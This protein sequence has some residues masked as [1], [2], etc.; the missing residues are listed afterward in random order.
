MKSSIA[1]QLLGD[2]FVLY[3]SIYYKSKQSLGIYPHRMGSQGFFYYS[4]L[5]YV[6]FPPL[7]PVTH[8]HKSIYRILLQFS[9]IFFCFWKLR[10]FL[11]F[12]LWVCNYK[13]GLHFCLLISE[14]LSLWSADWISA[15]NLFNPWKKITLTVKWLGR[16][17]TRERLILFF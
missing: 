3:P 17:E 8:P 2:F 9:P 15:V 7:M 5:V 11:S 12:L 6:F 10:S 13:R 1:H 4:L 16:G 14:C